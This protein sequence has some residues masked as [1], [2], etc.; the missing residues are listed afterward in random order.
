MGTFASPNESSETKNGGSGSASIKKHSL[1]FP[2]TN[3]NVMKS[4]IYFLLFVLIQTSVCF[5][6]IADVE[7]TFN[8]PVVTFDRA[9]SKDLVIPV[10]L[11]IG[12]TRA[13]PGTLQVWVS[14]DPV[15][16]TMSTARLGT[17]KLVN[18]RQ[19][20]TLTSNTRVMTFYIKVPADTTEYLNQSLGLRATL[21]L[22]GVQEPATNT[23]LVSLQEQP[24][25]AYTLHDY[26][27]TPDLKLRK[28]KSVESAANLLTISGEHKGYGNPV[29]V[30][31]VALTKGEVYTVKNISRSLYR[32]VLSLIS[33][34]VKVRPAFDGRPTFATSGLTNIGLNADFFGWKR[35]RYFSSGKMSTHRVG[36]GLWAAP[37]VEELDSAGTKGYL[38]GGTKSS[39]LFISSGLT[40]TYAYNS[41]TLVF[42]PAGFDF[43]TSKTGNHWAY[44]ARRWWG[45]GIGIDP[46]LFLAVLN[47]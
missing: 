10:T 33:V 17:V 40:L 4:G 5:G 34:P 15:S 27:S 39:Q 25:I 13:L 9:K 11:T 21:E 22:A 3:H 29:V 37:S 1:H 7:A 19:V 24:E 2:T 41:I 18:R 36:F 43:G 12:N 28:V 16:T 14:I 42:V 30:R 46:K 31:Q 44:S 23:F 8:R 45:F 6:Q 35:E 47:K 32:P 26:L 20:M 38:A